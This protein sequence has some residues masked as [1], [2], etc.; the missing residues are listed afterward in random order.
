MKLYFVFLASLWIL[1][2][3]STFA[4]T[5]NYQGIARNVQGAPL[6]NTPVAVRLLLPLPSNPNLSADETRRN[7][8]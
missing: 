7:T 8:Y 1:A 2:Y 4:Q 3:S 6:A 5:I